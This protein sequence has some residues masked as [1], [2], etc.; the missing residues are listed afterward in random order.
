MD[1]SGNFHHISVANEVTYS[2]LFSETFAAS[3]KDYPLGHLLV[4]GGP[5]DPA[6]V[7]G[8]PIIMDSTF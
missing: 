4:E 2:C 3:T 6:I 7:P 5:R 8:V 1:N